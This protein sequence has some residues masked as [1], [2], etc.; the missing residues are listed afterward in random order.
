MKTT[1]VTEISTAQLRKRLFFY[2]AAAL[3]ALVL[4]LT[5]AISFTLFGQLKKAENNS[6]VHLAEVRSMAVTEWCRWAKDVAEQI[7][8]RTR[9]RQELEKYNKKEISLAQLAGFTKPKLQDAMNHSQEVIGILRLDAKNRIVTSCGYGANLFR[10]NHDVAD[11]VFSDTVLSKPIMVED[12]PVIIVS[13]PIINRIGKRQGTDLALISLDPLKRII[14]HSKRLG[15]TGEIIVA[16]RSGTSVLPIIPFQKQGDH[17]SSA[18]EVS[19]AVKAFILMA[20]NGKTG[21][22]HTAGMAVA[23]H[24][25]EGT[26]FGLV[27]TQNQGELYSPIYKKMAIIGCLSLLIYFIILLGFWFLM[28]PLAGKILMHTDELEKRIRDKT[29]S[30]EKEI[31]ERKNAESEKEK[32]ISELQAAMREIKT[33]SGM[34]PICSNCKNI[35]DDKG[36][37]NRIEAYI[38]EHSDAQFSHGLCPDCAKKL[39]PEFYKG[40]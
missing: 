15:E 37:W 2:L 9:I 3:L 11:Y 13:A 22:G 19:P 20:V 33:L 23:Y 14:T 34:L 27:L 17:R 6:M 4:C 12:R 10:S 21:L 29:D 25:I 32:M 31:A 39:Y 5:M 18:S 16:Y 1:D 38:S 35:R 26:G 40:D 30:L 28:K 36:Y 24:P 8:S 7:T